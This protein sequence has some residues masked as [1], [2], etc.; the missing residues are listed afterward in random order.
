M[1]L[2]FLV[3]VK[4]LRSRSV[5]TRKQ[6]AADNQDVNFAIVELAFQRIFVVVG[7]VILLHHLVPK[8]YDKVI[9][10]FVNIV[11]AF[12]HIRGRN[13]HL[14]SDVAQ[15]IEYLLVAHGIA[16]EITRQHRLES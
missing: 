6:L 13:H 8:A 4:D 12:A 1:I 11:M 10:T 15:G 3:Y 5:I 14:R 16:F 9:G 2:K 7:I